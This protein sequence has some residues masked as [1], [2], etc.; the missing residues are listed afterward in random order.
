MLDRTIVVISVGESYG[1]LTMQQSPLK[2]AHKDVVAGLQKP[3]TIRYLPLDLPSI[4]S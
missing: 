4:I 2:L 3:Q 1:T